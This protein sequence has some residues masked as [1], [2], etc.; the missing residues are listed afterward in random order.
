MAMVNME[1]FE[2]ELLKAGTEESA[3]LVALG[4]EGSS[5]GCLSAMSLLDEDALSHG[6]RCMVEAAVSIWRCG[7]RGDGYDFDIC[8]AMSVLGN[9]ERWVLLR[10]L[11]HRFPIYR[12]AER[13][14][15]SVAERPPSLRS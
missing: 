11:T 3:L 7:S 5:K 14:V 1:A 15:L 2:R 4:F 13:G 10:A 12:Q 8:D 6:E 9:D